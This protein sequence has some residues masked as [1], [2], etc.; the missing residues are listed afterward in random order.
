[1]SHFI[2]LSETVKKDFTPI[3]HLKIFV[4]VKSFYGI[5]NL[6]EGGVYS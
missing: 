6:L 5:A 3:L 2:A 1:M 4:L